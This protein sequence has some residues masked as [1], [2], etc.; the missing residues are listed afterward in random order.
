MR[1]RNFSNVSASVGAR[2]NAITASQYHGDV[3]ASQTAMKGQ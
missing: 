3:G 1:S 2:I